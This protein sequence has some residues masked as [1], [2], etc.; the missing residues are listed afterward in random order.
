[1]KR[2]SVLFVL[3]AL[4]AGCV[5]S[6][7]FAGDR[8]GVVVVE[9]PGGPSAGDDGGLGRFLACLRTL[10]LTAAQKSDTQAIFDASKPILQ[11]DKDAVAAA[12]QKLRSD[13]EAGAD[14]CVIGQ[15]TLDARAAEQKLHADVESVKTQVL[16]TLTDAQKLRLRG[17]LEAPRAAASSDTEDASR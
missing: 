12:A 9:R 1:M 3:A 10:D 14:K 6:P 11:A 8:S 16:A 7:V 2:S 5:A 17:C 13:I 15:D 4:L